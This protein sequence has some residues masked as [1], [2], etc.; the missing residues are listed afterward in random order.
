M[1]DATVNQG[2]IYLSGTQTV[3][4]LFQVGTNGRASSRDFVQNE[5]SFVIDDGFDFVSGRVFGSGDVPDGPNMVRFIDGI[6]VFENKGTL[7]VGDG[8]TFEFQQRSFTFQN[9]SPPPELADVNVRSEGVIGG[10]GTLLG[11][12]LNE[13]GVVRP[14]MPDDPTGTLTIDG[15]LRLQANQT[16]GTLEIDIAG[17][18]DHDQLDI[19]GVAVLGGTLE[20]SLLN[21]FAPTAGQRFDILLAA[22]GV[23]GMFDQEVLPALSGGLA[24]D[25]L[26]EANAVALSVV[27]AILAGDY[28]GNGVVD[29][30][31]YTVWADNFGSTAALAADGNGNGVVD[32]ADYTI[33]ADNFGTSAAVSQGLVNV[34]EPQAILLLG[35]GLFA[36]GRRK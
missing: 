30:A 31:D 25:V 27:A 2:D 22:G 23:T 7:L 33:W 6:P 5:G 8:S 3:T 17:L 16:P 24:W 19:T 20:V 29:A 35:A 9:L 15:R 18:A 11:D 14:G 12:I 13:G 1:F 4:N 36:V 32:A 21:A 10:S 34:P 28:N 26:Y